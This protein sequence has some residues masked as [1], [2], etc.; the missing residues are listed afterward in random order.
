MRV[1]YDPFGNFP[2]MMNQFGN[3]MQNPIQ[4]LLQRRI[5]VPQNMMG[6]P[7]A[8]MQHMMNTGMLNQQQYNMA[9]MTAQQ[10]QNNPM[11]HQLMGRR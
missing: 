5:N 10:A 4:A 1:L 3:F 2:D 7:A 9:R 11:F 6:N 8:I